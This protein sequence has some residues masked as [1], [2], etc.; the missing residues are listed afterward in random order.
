L[1]TGGLLI[2]ATG[3]AARPMTVAQGPHRRG[4]VQMGPSG[5]MPKKET[6]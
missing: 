1:L 2:F 6:R 3:A 4:S 5:E